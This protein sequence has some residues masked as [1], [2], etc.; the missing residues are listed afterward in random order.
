M[1]F[2]RRSM[3]GAMAGMASLTSA[4]GNAAAQ[5]LMTGPGA[6]LM[7]S[8]G[9]FPIRLDQNENPN[10]PDAKVRAAMAAHFDTINRYPTAPYRQELIGK[11]AARHGVGPDS[12]LISNGSTPLINA[13]ILGFTSADKPLVTGAI[14]YDPV[15][16]IAELLGSSVRAIAPTP[17]LALDLGAMA[18][19]AKGAGLVYLCNHNNPTATAIGGDDIQAFVETVTRTSPQT[20]ILIDEAYF[21]YVANP[22]YRTAIPIA[23]SHPNV[24]VTRTFSKC[25]GLAGMRIGYVIADPEVIKALAMRQLLVGTNNLALA[26]AAALVDDQDY[27][28]GERRRNA[29]ARS[30]LTSFLERMGCDIVGADANFVLVNLGRNSEP[31]Q[32]ECARRG[33]IL[34]RR[35]KGLD[36]HSRIT[37]GTLAQI[38]AAC[39]IFEAALK[40]N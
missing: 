5:A 9:G 12:I 2:S 19:A 17:R 23:R 32:T 3:I 18:D 22:A 6:K 1:S 33:V 21:E 31:F 10:G 30:Y 28:E 25:F 29:Q 34:S 38:K 35:F 11:I 14:S 7:P 26:A 13:A 4:T 15:P 27:I 40:V 8:S 37:V 16:Y 36:S 20:R 24:V 39:E